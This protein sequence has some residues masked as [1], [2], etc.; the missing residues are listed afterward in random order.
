MIEPWGGFIEM[1][2]RLPGQVHTVLTNALAI[3]G[4]T[5]LPEAPVQIRLQC[6]NYILYSEM[7]GQAGLTA[8]SRR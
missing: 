8:L 3:V 4:W 7:L 6:Q 5:R 2:Y 1:D